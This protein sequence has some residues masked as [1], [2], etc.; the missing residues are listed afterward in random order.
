MD[1][2]K[3]NRQKKSLIPDSKVLRKA[4]ARSARDANKLA[5][6]FGVKVASQKVP[7]PRP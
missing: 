1:Q 6:A 3:S 4:L 2:A 5:K 7:Q